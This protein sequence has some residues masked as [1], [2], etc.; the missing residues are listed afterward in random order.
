MQKYG[1]KSVGIF[2]AYGHL[3]DIVIIKEIEIEIEIVKER[4]REYEK[5]WNFNIKKIGQKNFLT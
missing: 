3:S 2:R 5:R 1:L 4:G